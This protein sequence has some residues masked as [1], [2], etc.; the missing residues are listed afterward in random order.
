MT[1][2]LSIWWNFMED[3]R[4]F[5]QSNTQNRENFWL[6]RF[7]FFLI[8]RIYLNFQGMLIDSLQDYKKQW[9]EIKGQE[10]DN[11]TII[12]E[13]RGRQTY[14]TINDFKV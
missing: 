2:L 3:V 13:N 11:L 1:G 12:V 8:P 14:E 9:I 4:F 7:E 5:F 10:S 6:S